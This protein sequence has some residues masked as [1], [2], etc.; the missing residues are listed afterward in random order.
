MIIT[1]LSID[2]KSDKIFFKTEGCNFKFFFHSLTNKLKY[3]LL[4][5]KILIIN[6]LDFRDENKHE[7]ENYE[8]RY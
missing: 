3:D 2:H 1:R 7:S 8:K 4:T 6:L 5:I